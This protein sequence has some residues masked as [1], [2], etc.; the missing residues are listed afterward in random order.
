MSSEES[1]K[2]FLNHQQNL[3]EQLTLKQN[4]PKLKFCLAD[5]SFSPPFFPFLAG[6]Q[7]KEEKKKKREEE[8]E[9]DQEE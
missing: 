5:S 6:G 3:Q 1:E 4:Q 8:E 7:E 9:K 2:R